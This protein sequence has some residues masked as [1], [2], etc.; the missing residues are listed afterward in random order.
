MT[1]SDLGDADLESRAASRGV[2]AM[3]P[4]LEIVEHRAAHGPAD[5]GA[6]EGAAPASGE[7]ATRARARSASACGRRARRGTGYACVY[8]PVQGPGR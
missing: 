2:S 1:R 5:A 4:E 6:V 7:S 3:Q 8:L